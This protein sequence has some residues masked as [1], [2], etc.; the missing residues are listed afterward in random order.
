MY[1]KEGA[2][3]RLNPCLL[4]LRWLPQNAAQLPSANLMFEFRDL[5][6]ERVQLL[7]DLA[8]S[9]GTFRVIFFFILSASSFLPGLRLLRKTGLGQRRLELRKL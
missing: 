9:S 3:H 4:T 2:S 5:D 8:K 6:I 7:L 1:D